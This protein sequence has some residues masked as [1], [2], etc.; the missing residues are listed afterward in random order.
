MKLPDIIIKVF[1]DN[2]IKPCTI[3]FEDLDVQTDLP[4]ESS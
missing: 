1:C 4:L 3:I 2:F